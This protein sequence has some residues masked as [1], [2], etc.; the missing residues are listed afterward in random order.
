MLA[1][2]HPRRLHPG[3]RTQGFVSARVAFFPGV[4]YDNKDP[5]VSSSL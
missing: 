5:T 3:E 4:R 2:K 1:M